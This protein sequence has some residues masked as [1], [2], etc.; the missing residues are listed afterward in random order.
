MSPD[1]LSVLQESREP[2]VELTKHGPVVEEEEE[3]G[4]ASIKYDRNLKTLPSRKGEKRLSGGGVGGDEM[5][6][7]FSSTVGRLSSRHIK[8]KNEDLSQVSTSLSAGGRKG[9]TKCSEVVPYES[10]RCKEAEG[11]T[12]FLQETQESSL[13]SSSLSN[14][15]RGSAA[16]KRALNRGDEAEKFYDHKG[17]EEEQVILVNAISLMAAEESTL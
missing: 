1:E 8:P 11:E 10:S 13:Q 6:F 5:P 16:D 15:C 4:F 14:N 17:Q 9:L 12:R 3:G 2:S 7:H